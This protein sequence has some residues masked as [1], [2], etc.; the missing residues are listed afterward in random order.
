MT[1]EDVCKQ[2]PLRTA[3]RI[4]AFMG[5]ENIQYFVLIEHRVLCQVP[6]LQHALYIMFSAFYVFHLEYPKQTKNVMFFFQ[7]YIVAHPDSMKRPGTYLAV[8]SDIKKLASEH[9]TIH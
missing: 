5:E 3:P 2:P 9:D 8:V 4:A 6:S 7:D 1:P